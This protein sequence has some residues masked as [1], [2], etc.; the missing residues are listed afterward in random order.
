M[1]L[2]EGKNE[3]QTNLCL[4]VLQHEGDILSD[5]ISNEGFFLFSFRALCVEKE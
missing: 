1:W 5:S 4:S 2:V 3:K